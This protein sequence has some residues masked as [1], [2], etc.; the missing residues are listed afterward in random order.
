M[1]LKTTCMHRHQGLV[2]LIALLV[3]TFLFCPYAIAETDS[4]V[5]VRVGW[6]ESPFNTTDEYGRRSGYS[7]EYERKI[8]AY[9]GWKY[10]YGED[11][12]SELLAMLKRGEIDMLGDVSYTEERTEF[13]SFSSLPMGT[14]SYYIFITPEN[15]EITPD[16]FETLQHKRV[17]V[18]RGSIQRDMFVSWAKAHDIDVELVDLDV[19]Q[20]EA[21]D[22]LHQKKL[23]ALV[24]LD[25]FGGVSQDLTPICKIGSS[26][27]FFAVKKDRIDLL[28][29]LDATMSRI[30]DENMYYNQ[31]LNEKYLSNG[32]AKRYLSASENRWLA[33]HK[34]I[35]VGYQDNYLAFCAAD[36]NGHLTGALKDYLDYASTSFDNAH[37]SFEATPYPS[38]A[39]AVTALKAG[40]V[41]CIFPANMEDYDGELLGV[42]MS[43]PIMTT[44]MDAVIRASDQREFIRGDDIR[45]CVNEGNTNYEMFLMDAFPDWRIVY[46]PD[47]PAGLEAVAQNRADCLLISNYRYN[48]ISKLCERLHLTTIYTGV[49]MDYSFAMREGE[50]ELYSII[51]KAVKLVPD[52]TVHAA[53]AYYSSEDIRLSF[54]DIIQ[55]N[56]FYILAVIALILLVILFLL[57]R[58]SRA[59]KRASA[60]E[61]RA[62]E[63]NR[64]VFVDPL[65]SV[66]NRAAFINHLQTMQD[67]V[68]AGE[69]K[70]FAIGVFDCDNLKQINDQ[71][72]HDRGDIYIKSACH[73]I[74]TVFKHSPVFRIGGDEFCAILIGQDYE[75]RDEL[76]KTFARER[77]LLC[78][79]AD[80]AWEEPHI[81][82]GIAVYTPEEDDT[83]LTVQRRADRLMYEDKRKNKVGRS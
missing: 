38:A 21:I 52:S 83:V 55:E 80:N 36:E 61:S 44:E 79:A 62:N 43:A 13:M 58:S 54:A 56:L 73:L 42:V 18:N 3:V 23:D 10:E 12:W 71:Y 75:N 47:T 16:D 7:Y 8:A 45:V 57:V 63:L 37:L 60:E 64:Q 14:E 17:G 82:L 24:T 4:D 28:S 65:T 78:A 74:C 35:R 33:D 59:E 19:T 29:A 68:D 77:T 81:S 15:E 9:T 39:D 50:T 67:K 40:E 27:V 69:I 49:D 20:G 1:Y 51:A 41:D 31:M 26:N 48:N 2:W 70:E 53:L 11:S 32:T 34:T 66:R 72:G 46:A 25:I 5:V 22:L 76:P 30:Q 6:H